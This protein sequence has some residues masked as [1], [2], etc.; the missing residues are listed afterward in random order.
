[1]SFSTEDVSLVNG[2]SQFSMAVPP[3][4]ASLSETRLGSISLSPSLPAESMGAFLIINPQVLSIAGLQKSAILLND[5]S[6]RYTRNGN[7]RRFGSG[8]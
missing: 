6:Y 7:Y 4:V 3:P 2:C 8:I 5:G 1:M